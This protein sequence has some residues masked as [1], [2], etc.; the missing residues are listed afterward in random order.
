MEATTKIVGGLSE[1]KEDKTQTKGLLQRLEEAKNETEV[2]YLMGVGKTYKKVT[3]GTMRKWAKVAARKKQ[4][5][6]ESMELF[7][8]LV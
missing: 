3:V 1:F 5:I 6:K 8:T 2:D 4:Q 7:G